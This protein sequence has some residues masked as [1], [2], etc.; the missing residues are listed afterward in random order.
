MFQNPPWRSDD[1]PTEIE[2]E[3]TVSDFLT[4]ATSHARCWKASG[5][6]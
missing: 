5:T 4:V 1:T 6:P 3:A 2:T